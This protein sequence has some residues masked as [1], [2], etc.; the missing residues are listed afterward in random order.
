MGLLVQQGP[1][2]GD[3]RIGYLAQ[4]FFLANLEDPE[5]VLDFLRKLRRYMAG[6]LE[7]LESIE[8]EWR[9]ADPG[10]PDRLP[11][12]DFFPQ[13]TLAMGLKKF[14]ASV[15]WCDESIARIEARQARDGRR[16]RAN[17]G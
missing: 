3:E 12:E 7:H 16:R 6:Q 14:A 17:S 10:Y 5:R 13:L 1:T 11:D 15:E 4:V 9:K 2:V 8:A